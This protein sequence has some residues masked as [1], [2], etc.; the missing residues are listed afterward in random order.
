MLA[1]SNAAMHCKEMIDAMAAK[2]YWSTPGG[3][4]PHA[5]LYS[6]ITREIA[7]KGDDSRFRKAERGRF[8]LVGSG[9]AS[10]GG[11]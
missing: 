10:G 6:A 2:G 8:E 5:T 3:R 11:P 7:M 1:E 4:T 9:G